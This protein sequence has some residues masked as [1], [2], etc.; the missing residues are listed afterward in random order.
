[1]KKSQRSEV[2]KYLQNHK[3]GITSMKAFELFGATR[4]S[5]IIFELRRKGHTIES[6]EEEITNRYGRPCKYARYVLIEEE[7]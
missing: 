7:N 5:A 1:M 2:L 6:V 3:K 4:L